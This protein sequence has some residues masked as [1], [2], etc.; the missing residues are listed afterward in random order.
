MFKKKIQN[1][2]QFLK[3]P[4]DSG[5]HRVWVDREKFNIDFL[6]QHFFLAPIY[7]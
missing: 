1:F 3:S 4:W 5:T 6:A 7:V 2:A